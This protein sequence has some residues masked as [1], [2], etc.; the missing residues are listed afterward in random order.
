MLGKHCDV[1]TVYVHIKTFIKNKITYCIVNLLNL[2]NTDLIQVFKLLYTLQH[3]D[4]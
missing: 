3:V 2:R 1:C 4:V